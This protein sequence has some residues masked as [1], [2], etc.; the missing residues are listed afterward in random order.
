M[1]LS[2]IDAA[3]FLNGTLPDTNINN[4]SLDNVTGLP[5]GVGGKVLQVVTATDT[6]QRQTN[7]SSYVSAN[8][9]V[10]ITPSS[11]SSKILVFYSTTIDG[12]DGVNGVVVTLYRNGTNIGGGS[13]GMAQS[14]PRLSGAGINK[15][16]SP[17]TTSQVTYEVYFRIYSGSSNVEVNYVG[18]QGNL[19]AMEIQG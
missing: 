4:A 2:K 14:Y 5:A 9:S 10:N 18:S 13:N 16:D 19:T 12:A 7:S 11:T 3:N 8:I 17:S 15:L 6:T 1:A